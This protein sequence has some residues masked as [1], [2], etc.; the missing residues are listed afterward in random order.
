MDEITVGVFRPGFSY[1]ERMVSTDGQ[2]TGQPPPSGKTENS[3]E[4]ITD[5]FPA[6]LPRTPE[7]FQ[8]GSNNNSDEPPKTNELVPPGYQLV[9]IGSLQNSQAT[10]QYP[11]ISGIYPGQQ[12]T[13][14]WSPSPVT[15]ASYPSH[16]TSVGPSRSRIDL[17]SIK[18]Q[19]PIAPRGSRSSVP[20]STSHPNRQQQPNEL[21]RIV[22][23][24]TVIKSLLAPLISPLNIH[25]IIIYLQGGG[26]G[27]G[28]GGVYPDSAGFGPFH[29]S[30]NWFATSSTVTTYTD[31]LQ[32][33][34]SSRRWDWSPVIH[35]VGPH[36][37]S[38]LTSPHPHSHHAQQQQQSN[39]GAGAHPSPQSHY[40]SHPLHSSCLA[41]NNNNIG[42]H[43]SHQHHPS[44]SNYP[45]NHHPH[46]QHQHHIPPHN[47]HHQL[48]NNHHQQQQQQQTLNGN[49]N[50]SNNTHRPFIGHNHQQ[51]QQQPPPSAPA[52]S[53]AAS[54]SPT[55][56]T[57]SLQQ[58]R[59]KLLI[60]VGIIIT[61]PLQ[62]IIPFWVTG[63]RS[64][65]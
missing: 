19:G 18:A 2:V 15:S 35:L 38:P 36:Q 41:N 10:P 49:I 23:L 32:Q 33:W 54:S 43:P 21:H 30:R 55:I 9:P 62:I 13:A 63:F 6:S 56:T 52:P 27:V 28:P 8:C 37:P 26:N 44:I 42:S 11:S 1:Q 16:P 14:P 34:R 4:G 47:H 57:S 64:N 29:H 60:L 61:R 59:L 45:T 50:L 58:L 39:L 46:Q 20:T 17:A 24:A 25:R 51:Q 65:T 3:L 12:P 22:T 40:I 7:R 53:S 5:D 31:E 48:I